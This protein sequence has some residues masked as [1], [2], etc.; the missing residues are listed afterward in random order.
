MKS[1][2][3][4]VVVGAHGLVGA[5]L[6]KVL[7]Q[8][9]EVTSIVRNVRGNETGQVREVNLESF[10][11]SEIPMADWTIYCAGTNGFSAARMFPEK[12]LRVNVEA[13]VKIAEACKSANNRFLYLSSNAVFDCLEPQMAIDRI[14]APRG[15]YG[16]HKSLAEKKLRKLSVVVILRL[17][18]IVDP[19]GLV[20]QWKN[21]LLKN[22]GISAVVNHSISPLHLK[23]VTEIIEKIIRID[24][25]GIYQISASDDITYFQLAEL[26]ATSLS[27]GVERVS[28]VTAVQI[29][30][31]P[32]EVMAFASMDTVRA[33][34][35]LGFQASS[36][37]DTILNSIGVP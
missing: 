15:I 32:D 27:I 3:R 10:Q 28:P 29:G 7:S 12:S 31:H 4:I 22:D 34:E 33:S 19:D 21:S 2:E 1:P 26:I 14:H 16:L 8:Q 5:S 9:F 30:I 37:K 35:D 25:S 24:A 6:V 11:V 36:S 17:G 13:P 20:S 18:K 23:S